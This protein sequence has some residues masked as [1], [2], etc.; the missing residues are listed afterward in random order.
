MHFSL[1]F[2]LRKIGKIFKCFAILRI[3]QCLLFHFSRRREISR[4]RK[5]HR[6]S[7]VQHK[8][9]LLVKTRRVDCH[10][11]SLMVIFVYD[12]QLLDLQVSERFGIEHASENRYYN[13]KWI[14]VAFWHWKTHVKTDLKTANKLRS[15]FGTRTL[16]I[17][18]DR[19][20]NILS[21]DK[22]MDASKEV[23]QLFLLQESQHERD[24]ANRSTQICPNS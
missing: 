10:T 2:S 22:K 7:Q 15:R 12:N 1:C 16:N 19:I 4:A 8:A 24:A 23:C 11:Y 3:W 14:E 18:A 9:L 17:V 5:M 20:L 21:F 6:N 13:C